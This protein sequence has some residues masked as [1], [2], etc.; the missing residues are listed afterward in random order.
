[1]FI[2]LSDY[3]WNKEELFFS[4]AWRVDFYNVG[5]YVINYQNYTITN[6]T[7]KT[8]KHDPAQKARD[9]RR[10]IFQE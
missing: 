3:V 1:V 9:A 8:L 2:G 5:C 6:Y 4:S 7:A 10:K